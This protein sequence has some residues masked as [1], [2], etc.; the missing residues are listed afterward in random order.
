MTKSFNDY[1]LYVFDLDGTLYDQ[2]R[3]RMMMALRLMGYYA[4]HPFSAYDLLILKH[5]RSVKD[6]WTDSS[7][8]RDIINRTAED[9]GKDPERVASI[10]RRW[11][12]DSPLDVITKTA[13]KKLISLIDRLRDNGKKVVVL[14][15]YPTKDKLEA[16]KVT[17]DGS[18]GP[19]DERIDELKPSPKGLRIIMEDLS[20]APGDVIMIGDRYEKDGKSAEAAGVDHLILPRRVKKRK[21]DEI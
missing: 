13:D 20:V 5:F 4:L 10:V 18:Y 19:E 1:K 3:L 9:L 8:E 7:S 11:I 16:L 14:S 15:D 12:Y 6:S 2:P 21:L 17:V